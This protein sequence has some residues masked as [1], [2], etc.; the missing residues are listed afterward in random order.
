M[1]L[2]ELEPRLPAPPDELLDADTLAAE[3]QI[4]E[5]VDG[6]LPHYLN[7]TRP[8]KSEAALKAAAMAERIA[9][10]EAL[11]RASDATQAIGEQLPMSREEFA[12]YCF[13]I[14]P[15]SNSELGRK[16]FT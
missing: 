16:R 5:I 2:H 1:V 10:G 13:A 9:R 7:E 8:A 15:I 3:L 14:D 11:I 6:T 4:A 12:D